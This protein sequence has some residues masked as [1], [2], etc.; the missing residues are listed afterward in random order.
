MPLALITGATSGLGLATARALAKQELDLV[1]VGRNVVRGDRIVLDLRRRYPRCRARFS[2]TDLS[3]Q[4]QVRNLAETIAGN[5][6]SIDILINNAGAR[7]DK[8]QESSEGLERTF[9]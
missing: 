5:C 4:N 6:F 7:F 3:E 1:L 2:R 9:A 8:Y